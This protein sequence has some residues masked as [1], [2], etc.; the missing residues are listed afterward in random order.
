MCIRDRDKTRL[1]PAT[2]RVTHTILAVNGGI[3]TGVLAINTPNWA[4]QPIGFVWSF[5]GWL[6]VF[7]VLCGIGVTLSGIRDAFASR[8]L[9]YMKSESPVHFSDT[10][11]RV[12]V[13]GGTGFIGQLLVKALIQDG[14]DVTLLTRNPKITAWNFDGQVRCIC[15]LY[16]SRCV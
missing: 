1:L 11:Q 4:M 10:P 5:Q 13:T 14:H 9:K 12:L 15:L 8:A 7:L 6:S 16:T 2:E 3:F